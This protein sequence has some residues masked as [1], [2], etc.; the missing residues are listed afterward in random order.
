MRRAKVYSS[1]DPEV[2]DSSPPNYN[3]DLNP[4]RYVVHMESVGQPSV[5]RQ[6]SQ[7]MGNKHTRRN[8]NGTQDYKGND[9]YTM[10]AGLAMAAN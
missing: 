6:V 5:I 3:F 1:M 8:A 9:R 10:W 4:K 7:P 2:R